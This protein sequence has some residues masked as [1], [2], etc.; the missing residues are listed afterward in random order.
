MA[1]RQKAFVGQSL[2]EQEFAYEVRNGERHQHVDAAIAD[3]EH[4]VFPTVWIA[5][6]CLMA[7]GEPPEYVVQHECRQ[8]D[9]APVLQEML[10]LTHCCF[11]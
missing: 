7:S 9:D 8:G 5:L 2:V 10:C 11:F 3:V 1:L 6:Q 4:E